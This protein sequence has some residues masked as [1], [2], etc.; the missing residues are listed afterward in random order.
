VAGVTGQENSALMQGFND[1]NPQIQDV[2][3][4]EGTS[5]KRRLVRGA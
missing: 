1:P 4:D 5:R 2:T 3:P